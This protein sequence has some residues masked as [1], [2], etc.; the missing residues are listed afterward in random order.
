MCATIDINDADELDEFIS[1]ASLEELYVLREDITSG[2]AF[3]D[4]D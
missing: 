1:N 2:T 3:E 4:D